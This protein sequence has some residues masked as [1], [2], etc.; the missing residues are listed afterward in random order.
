MNEK[1]DQ[2]YSEC[3]EELIVEVKTNAMYTELEKK[4]IIEFVLEK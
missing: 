2:F 4:Q 1:I 3:I